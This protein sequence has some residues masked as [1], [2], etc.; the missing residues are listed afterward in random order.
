MLT[1]HEL[2]NYAQYAM[3]EEIDYLGA[4]SYLY[5]SPITSVMI[6]AGPCVLGLAFLERRRAD[7]TL[8]IIDYNPD[9]FQYVD[10]H[11]NAAD[12]PMTSRHYVMGDSSDIGKTWNKPVDLLIV[13]GDH[14]FEG[15]NKDI[16]A[17]FPHVVPGGYIF[18]HDVL[19]REGGFNGAGVWKPGGVA[20]AIAYADL[21]WRWV[22]NVG[23]SS[24]YEK[25]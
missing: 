4:L 24:V 7:H 2:N 20:K 25:I 22:E 19:E 8:H 21:P 9:L 14:T 23:I 12:I 11:L 15:V 17:W 18:F 6:G 3:P 10:A 13:D 5:E 16:E 1:A